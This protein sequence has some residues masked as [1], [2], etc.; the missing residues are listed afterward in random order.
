MRITE[1]ILYFLAKLFY[2]TEAAH[3]AE[4]KQALSSR[5]A[6]NTYRRRQLD[7][8]LAAARRYGVD[9][10]DKM[11]L[12]LGCNDGAI[13]GGYVERGARRVVGV[14]ID[15]DAIRRAKEQ[16]E[17]AQV[18]FCASQKGSI[19]VPDESCDVVLSYDVFEHVSQPAAILEECHRLLKPGGQ[20][21]IGTWGWYHPFAPHLWA[22][23]PV[24]WAHVFVS[25]RTLLRTCRRVYQAP[26]YV[27]N[28]HDLDEN[29]QK[30][31]DKFQEEAISPEYLNKLFIRDFEK[32][33]RQSRFDFKV[34][35]QPFGSRFARW[36]KVFLK[37]PWVREFLTSYIWVVLT[38]RQP[39]RRESNH[40][41][42]GLEC[43]TATA[44]SE[45]AA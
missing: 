31:K 44:R 23:M 6:N 28:M 25:E 14:D 5:A 11:V 29:G 21:L 36:T 24:P 39:A 43:R 10:T 19:P 1:N 15:E 42:P 12:D 32:L 33:F 35:P 41:A 2:R 8:V 30:R 20:L 45:V 17:S 16:H 27:P 4:M 34:Y 40:P 18:S 3:S 37:V 9:I 22:T 13:T 38:K 26:W 7:L